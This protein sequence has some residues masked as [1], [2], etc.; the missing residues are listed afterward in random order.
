MVDRSKRVELVEAGNNVMV[1]N[2]SQATDPESEC[3]VAARDCQLETGSLNVAVGQPQTLTYLSQAETGAHQTSFLPM[4]INSLSPP[5]SCSM[6]L[7]H[8]MCCQ[9]DHRTGAKLLFRAFHKVDSTDRAL[10]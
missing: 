5:A 3:S 2:D 10:H 7:N 9:E 1:L 8:A 4:K 6:S